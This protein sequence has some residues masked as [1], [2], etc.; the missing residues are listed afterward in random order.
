MSL[1]GLVGQPVVT[2]QSQSMQWPAHHRVSPFCFRGYL[3]LILTPA[4]V[5]QP[6]WSSQQPSEV[7]GLALEQEGVSLYPRPDMWVRRILK[8]KN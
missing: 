4:P 8:R 7:L 2:T 1:P 3:S 6:L 5:H